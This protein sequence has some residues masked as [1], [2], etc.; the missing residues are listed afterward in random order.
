MKSFEKISS[1]LAT[2][3]GVAAFLY[4]LAFVVVSK[5]NPVTGSVLSALF[6][7]IFGV[8]SSGAWVGLYKKLREVDPGF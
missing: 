3:A 7:M 2:F 4:A 8:L 6:L 1:V 5:N